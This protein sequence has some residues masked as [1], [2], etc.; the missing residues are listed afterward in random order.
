MG[1][2]VCSASCAE[3]SKMLLEAVDMRFAIRYLIGSEKIKLKWKQLGSVLGT[4]VDCWGSWRVKAMRC[5][6]AWEGS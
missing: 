5:R 1:W 3:L 4:F 6:D 2:L